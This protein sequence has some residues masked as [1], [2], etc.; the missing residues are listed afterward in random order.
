[1]RLQVW[2]DINRSVSRQPTK[3]TKISTEKREYYRGA[4]I[5]I[6]DVDPLNTFWL[7]FGYE[8]CRLP[9]HVQQYLNFS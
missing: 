6:L 4:F 2:S 3:L 7:N 1:M 9:T 8:A 5:K